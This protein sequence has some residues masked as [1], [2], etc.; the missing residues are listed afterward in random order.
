METV[1]EWLFPMIGIGAISFVVWAHFDMKKDRAEHIVF[2]DEHTKAIRRAADDMRE[3]VDEYK[4]YEKR[5]AAHLAKM[6]A[7]KETT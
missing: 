2:M 3:A 6:R 4:E 7:V 1:L 5:I